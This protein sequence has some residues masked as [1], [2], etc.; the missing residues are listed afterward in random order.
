MCWLFVPIQNCSTPRR[1][2]AP[3]RLKR[4]LDTVLNLQAD[5]DD[6]QKY[7]K[8]VHT[9]I[10]AAD[11]NPEAHEFLRSLEKSHSQTIDQVEKLYASLNVP[12][13][14]PEL[15]GLSLP[16]VRT[17]LM[18]RDLKINI[19]KRAIGSFFEW[20]KLDRAAGGRDQ[21]LGEHDNLVF[22]L[23]T[24]IRRNCRY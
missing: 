22:I 2:D 3:A 23:T 21:P 17:L 19:R 9:N 11:T 10:A 7:M 15:H 24:P 18:A 4:E 8:T 1:K 14:F 5:L 12:D 13:E 16:F 20:D 6:I